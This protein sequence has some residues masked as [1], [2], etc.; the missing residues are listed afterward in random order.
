MQ[1]LRWIWG[2]QQKA[3]WKVI[4][5]GLMLSAIQLHKASN[6]SKNWISVEQIMSYTYICKNIVFGLESYWNFHKMDPS[7]EY[8]VTIV[9]TIN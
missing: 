8:V 5:V 2:K 3:I 7:R 6:I 1:N 4:W 9:L